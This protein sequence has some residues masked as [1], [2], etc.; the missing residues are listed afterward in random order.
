A[1]VRDL[2]LESPAHSSPSWTLEN[3][4]SADAVRHK[5]LRQ[6]TGK[7]MG[8]LPAGA[9]GG[10]DQR[11]VDFLQRGDGWW[12]ERLEERAGQM[13]SADDGVHLLNPSQLLRV[14]NGFD[15]PRVPTAGEDHESLVLDIHHDGLVVMD[16]RVPLP[17][18]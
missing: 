15:R 12:D 14:T 10:D 13:K 16:Q 4:P 18:A 2:G 9:M 1:T 8:R 5:G 17:L 6:L 3:E 11:R 7:R